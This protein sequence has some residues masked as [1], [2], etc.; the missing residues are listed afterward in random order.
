[1]HR[2]VWCSQCRHRHTLRRPHLTGGRSLWYGSGLCRRVAGFCHLCATSELRWTRPTW[3]FAGKI[4]KHEAPERHANACAWA[5]CGSFVIAGSGI[6]LLLCRCWAVAGKARVSASG[7]RD[8][9]WWSLL[10]CYHLRSIYFRICH[11]RVATTVC[12][13]VAW[14][15]DVWVGVCGGH[16][17]GAFVWQVAAAGDLMSSGERGLTVV[18]DIATSFK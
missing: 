12:W 5:R 14:V 9:G 3:S 7:V 13:I 18:K 1:M 6:L 8:H 16:S 11:R 2:P 10:G 15:D 4:A 17:V